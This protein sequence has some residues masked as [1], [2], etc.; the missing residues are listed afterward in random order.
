MERLINKKTQLFA[1]VYN[2]KKTK[3]GFEANIKKVKV[4]NY[5][6]VEL[7]IKK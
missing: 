3:N 7:R 5:K 1:Y 4:F 2:T 6:V